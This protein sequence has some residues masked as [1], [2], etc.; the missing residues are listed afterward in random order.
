MILRIPTISFVGDLGF[1]MSSSISTS[2]MLSFIE[3]A[4]FPGMF[5]KGPKTEIANSIIYLVTSGRFPGSD[6]SRWRIISLSSGRLGG[7]RGFC[8]T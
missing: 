4:D 2:A 6:A 3:V 1:P 8:L 7:V 5:L